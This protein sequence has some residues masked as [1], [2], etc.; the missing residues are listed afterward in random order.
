MNTPLHTR[1]TVLCAIGASLLGVACSQ[2]KLSPRESYQL[3]T[4]AANGFSQHLGAAGAP[5]FVMFDPQCRHCAAMW[6]ATAPLSTLNFVW[7]PVA[8][9]KGSRS[10]AGAIV[11]SQD[12]A[13]TFAAIK[14]DELQT[15]APS[16]AG[17]A[18][19][20]SNTDLLRKCDASAVPYLVAQNPDETVVA[21]QGARKTDEIAKLFIPALEGKTP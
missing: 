9:L 19:V 21:L 4:M 5:I 11:D 20:D 18:V 1:R 17:L 6:E 3:L 15:V 10:L 13:A 12:P 14:R 7:V 8:V 2:E 16:A